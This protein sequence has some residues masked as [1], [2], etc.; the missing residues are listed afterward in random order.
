MRAER[1]A[2][3]GLRGIPPA[4]AKGPLS[5]I[6]AESSERWQSVKGAPFPRGLRTLDRLPPFWNIDAEGKGAGGLRGLAP[7]RSMRQ[8]L[9]RALRAPLLGGRSRSLF[10]SELFS[11]WPSVH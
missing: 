5:L 11:D 10:S 9:M 1:A 2:P 6:S 8:R 3:P 7:W 4:L